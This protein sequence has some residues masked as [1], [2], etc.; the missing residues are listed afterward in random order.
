MDLH[1]VVIPAGECVQKI[2]NVLD[3]KIIVERIL[4]SN[5][6]AIM[7]AFEVLPSSPIAGARLKD[8]A[9]PDL[10]DTVR[11]AAVL[12]DRQHII[13]HGDTIIVPGDKV[14]VAGQ[15]EKVASMVRWNSPDNSD[16]NRVAIAGATRIGKELARRLFDE[17]YNVRLIEK[18]FKTGAHLLDDLKAGIMVINGDP[19]DKE[20][21][22]EAGVDASDAFVS[23]LDDDE[24][25]I[26]S[27]IMAKELG[28]KKVV[29]VTNKAE[30]VNIIPAIDMIDSGFSSSL[31]AV[32]T[33]LRQLDAEAE[34]VSVDAILNRIDAYVFEF[35][36]HS[37]S[38]VCGKC[39]NEIKF[40]LSTVLAVVFRKGNVISAAGNLRLEENDT[41]ATVTTYDKLKALEPLFEKK[42]LLNL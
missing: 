18:D 29:T 39:I 23:A 31:V 28:A 27:C 38:Q 30:Y 7:T 4:F 6:D 35:K 32:N 16:I 24:D 3:N 40:P 8:I 19:T 9:N 21:L 2:M 34:T 36:V 25:N 17:G 41:V 10:L 26:L 5:P 1:N 22:V 20:V 13:P 11:F 33:V 42:G 12:R 37:G 14:Y 15:R